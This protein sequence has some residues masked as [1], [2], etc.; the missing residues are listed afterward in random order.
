LVPPPY[1]SNTVLSSE[2]VTLFAAGGGPAA[3]E[4]TDRGR[5]SVSGGGQGLYTWSPALDIANARSF[6][7]FQAKV[8]GVSAWKT[9]TRAQVLDVHTTKFGAP[10]WVRNLGTLA[11]SANLGPDG[12]VYFATTQST[13]FRLDGATGATKWSRT[14]MGPIRSMPVFTRDDATLIVSTGRAVRGVRAQ[15]GTLVWRRQLP[16]TAGAPSVAA[17]GTVLVGSESG[18]FYGIDPGNGSLRWTRPLTG[19]ALTPAATLGNAAFVASGN[20]LH[21]L[22][23][24]DGSVLW[25]ATLPGPGLT[26]P[27]AS[28]DGLVYV[29]SGEWVSCYDQTGALQWSHKTTGVGGAGEIVVGEEGSLFVGC[30]YGSLVI[31]RRY[32]RILL[33]VHGFGVGTPERPL[34]FRK[35]VPPE[36]FQADGSTFR[37]FAGRNPKE[38][39]AIAKMTLS[40]IVTYS[41]N[42]EVDFRIKD[43]VIHSGPVERRI[44]V[45]DWNANR[46]VMLDRRSVGPEFSM[47]R[48]NHAAADDPWAGPFWVTYYASGE[49]S[50]SFVEID[51]LTVGQR[52]VWWHR[53]LPQW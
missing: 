37:I 44:H 12:D 28:P 33:T 17:D 36:F 10:L 35:E 50:G 46:W 21:S 14:G 11:A 26:S 51:Q 7:P 25:T 5:V 47:T 27:S 32:S 41:P 13:L 24:A 23:T 16:T 15:D 53:R 40:T 6:F 38:P 42:V 20:Q 9:P 48:I 4:Y 34:G 2:G 18:T 22:S 19:T 31:R 1:V 52:P 45:Y 43:R 8:G 30:K 39:S 49:V 29:G 3:N